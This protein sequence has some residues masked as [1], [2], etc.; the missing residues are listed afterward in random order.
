HLAFDRFVDPF[1]EKVTG[2][3]GHEDDGVAHSE[4]VLRMASRIREG[5]PEGSALAIIRSAADAADT[6]AGDI[7]MP[8]AEIV[9]F[10]ENIRP[11]DLLEEMLASRFTRVP[12][13]RGTVDEILGKVHLKDVIRL[14]RAGGVDLHS[15]LRP[16]LRVP[17]RKP[18]LPLLSDMQRAFIHLAI[19][20]DE[21]GRTLGL[22]TQED[23]LEELVGEIRD[24]FDREELLTV[25][26]VEDGSYRALGRVKVADF[27]RET[28][29]EVPAEPGD[30][31]SGLLFNALGHPGREGELV[32]LLG[33]ELKVLAASGTRITEVGVRR[34]EA[35]K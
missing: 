4:E 15:I 19:V 35:G 12:I 28:G 34:G 32:E 33:Y 16:V 27:N 31:L 20:K 3:H 1:V 13:H 9:T 24:E 26:Q 7:M 25:R 14:V 2:G 8:A 22:L 30:S 17:P 21:F 5:Q 6:T 23:V 29:W 10:E 11:E 18:I